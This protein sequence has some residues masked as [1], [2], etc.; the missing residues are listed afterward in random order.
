MASSIKTD[1]RAN[2][3]NKLSLL[4]VLS[5]RMSHYFTCSRSL[6]IIG[7][8]VRLY[9]KILSEWIFRI[10]L[11]DVTTIGGGFQIFHGGFGTVI[12]PKV[13][14]GNNVKIR[15]HTTIGGK[16]FDGKGPRPVIGNNVSI[17]PG[18]IILGGIHIGDNACIGA[19]SVVVKDVEANEVVAGN[20]ARHIRYTQAEQN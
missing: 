4:L 14:I 13:V 6:R 15:H 8:P 12:G 18:C 20:P 11:K 10:Q 7:F 9:Y 2:R 5:F 16:G 17:G 3:G 1:I 19:G